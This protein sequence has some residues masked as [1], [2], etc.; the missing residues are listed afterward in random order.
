MALFPK[1]VRT[2]CFYITPMYVCYV[3]STRPLDGA[4]FLIKHLFTYYTLFSIY[5][6]ILRQ[7]W[8]K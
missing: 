3:C 8:S 7:I 2:L 4:F 5:L 1:K 6:H